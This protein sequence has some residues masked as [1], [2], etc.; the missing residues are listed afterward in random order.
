MNPATDASLH[1]YSFPQDARWTIHTPEFSADITE[2][3][4]ELTGYDPRLRELDA[5][6][7]Y[8]GN[9]YYILHKLCPA[10]GWKVERVNSQPSR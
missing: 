8:S 10:R 2:Y 6:F 9:A 4:S 5:A 7:Q 3:N 1:G